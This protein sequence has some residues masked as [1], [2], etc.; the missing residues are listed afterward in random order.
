MLS[1]DPQLLLII[2]ATFLLAGLVK[3]VTGLGLPTVCLAIL[4]LVLDLPS[5]MA[6]LLVPSLLTNLQQAFSGGAFRTLLARLW[7]FLL[8][9]VAMVGLGARALVSV[10]LTLLSALLGLVL[11]CYGLL[12]LAGLKLQISPQRERAS[13]IG[14]GLINGLLTGMTGSFVVPGVLYLQAIGLPRDQLVQ[15]M[16]LLFSVSTL[17][18]GLALGGQQLLS[19]ELGLLSLIGVVPALGG[20]WLGQRLRRRMAEAMFRRVLFFALILLGG[21]LVAGSLN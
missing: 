13:G 1:I 19:P 8:A 16:G 2:L 18:L 7:P 20:M 5:A 21:Y 4:T 14:L 6:L 11:V 12:S 15:A 9:A 3:G 10:E 17:A